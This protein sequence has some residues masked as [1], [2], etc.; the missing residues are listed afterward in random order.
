MYCAPRFSQLPVFCLL[1][2]ALPAFAQT[3]V[4][5]A[6]R[7]LDVGTGQIF[8]PAVIVIENDRIRSVNRDSDSAGPS[9]DL[10]DVTLLPGLMDMH[11]HLSMDIGPNW[12]SRAVTE[13]PADWSLRGARNAR[14]TLLAG[15]TTVRDVGSQDFVDV[16]LM[17]AVDRG[18]IVG[19]RI[20]PSGNALGVTGGH[21]DI[22]GFAPGIRELGPKEGVADGV[23]EVVKAVR[24]QIKH[25]ARVI[26]TCA[27]AGVLSFEKTVGAQEYSQH[28][29]RAMVEEAARHGLKVAA[30]AH[31]AE[32]ITAAVE[33]GVASIEHGSTLTKESIRLMKKRGTYL[34]PTVYLMRAIDMDSLPPHI[35][36]KAEHVLPIAQDSIRR[37]ISAG[38]KIAFGTDAGVYPHGDNAREFAV[39]VELGMT[40]LQTIRAATIDAAALLGV[41]DRGRIAAGLL[42][43]LI[44]V[45]GNPLNDIEA[46][47][48]VRFVMKGGQVFK[49]P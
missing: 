5:R 49:Q 18:F 34:V 17:K 46:M 41:E 35:R 19:P 11:T 21:C 8:E 25:G 38:V 22:T 32:G 29:L 36:G 23:D 28:E 26:K 14:K 48:D 47:E 37:A 3:Q 15:F 1:L 40:P 7:M 16:A 4:V 44:A 39:L 2:F 27:T 42:A 12:I 45:A 9:I 13:A 33:A 30:H 43:D 10:G 20:V 6:A 24:Y 31:G